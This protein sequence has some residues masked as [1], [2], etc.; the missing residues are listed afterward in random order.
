M[1]DLYLLALA[2]R[3][4]GTFVTFDRGVVVAAVRGAIGGNLTVL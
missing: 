4:G 2:V 3:R 1:T